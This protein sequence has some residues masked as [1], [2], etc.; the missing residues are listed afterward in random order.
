MT[1]I[2]L[3][4]ESELYGFALLFLGVGFLFGYILGM[5]TKDLKKDQA[6]Q[7]SPSAR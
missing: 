4:T 1:E 6:D 2:P 5:G 7:P 3:F